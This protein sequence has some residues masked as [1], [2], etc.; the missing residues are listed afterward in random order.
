MRFL[1]KLLLSL[2]LGAGLAMPLAHAQHAL[3]HWGEDA[4]DPRQV[5]LK[6]QATGVVMA[7][8]EENRFIYL[9]H[10]AIPEMTW[11]AQDGHR[12][13]VKDPAVL[14]GLDHGTPVRFTV[15]HLGTVTD[16]EVLTG[17]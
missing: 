9:T 7:V 10:E 3:G 8:D 11:P 15:D 1:S 2:V 14:I 4:L 17:Q 5:P 12:L 6:V 13:A 16:I